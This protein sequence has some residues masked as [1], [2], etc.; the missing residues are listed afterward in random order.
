MTVHN[1]YILGRNGQSL[2][3]H[4]WDR[5]SKA[6]LSRSEEDKLMA[7]LIFSLK[8]F[9][10]KMST[11]PASGTFKG[12]RVSLTIFLYFIETNFQ[13][14]KYRLHY[15]ESPT[16]IKLILNTSPEIL[17]CSDTLSTIYYNLLVPIIIKNPLI[18]PSEPIQSE[19]FQSKLDAFIK[20]LT[21]F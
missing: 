18:A 8:N 14:S 10:R 17:P 16:G 5:Q 13:T 2:F 11:E 7:G 12:L 21:F 6:T 1:L 4:E 9:C 3:Y 15:W 20:N 19:L